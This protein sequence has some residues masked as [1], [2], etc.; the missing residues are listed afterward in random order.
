MI[1]M[2]KEVLLLLLLLMVLSA[3]NPPE[4]GGQSMEHGVHTWSAWF[5]PSR[6]VLRYT[7]IE[8]MPSR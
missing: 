4:N 6:L 1:A 5:L 8:V 3:S 2:M 7:T